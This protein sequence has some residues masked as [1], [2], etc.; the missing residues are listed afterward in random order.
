MKNSVKMLSLCLYLV[1]LDPKSVVDTVCLSVCDIDVMHG[2]KAH[3]DI[4]PQG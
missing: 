4:S 3:E 1:A 2:T